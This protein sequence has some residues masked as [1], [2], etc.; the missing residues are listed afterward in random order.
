VELVA[1]SQDGCTDTAQKTLHF[2]EE[3]TIYWPSSFSPNNDGVND[4]FKIEGEFISLKDF[5]LLIYDRW[6]QQVFGSTNPTAV[7]DGKHPNGYSTHVAGIYAIQLRYRNHL[8]ELV[9]IFDEVTISKAGN[10]VGLR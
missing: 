5:E 6:G 2:I 7:W 8:G 3:T 10:K 4:V 1:T 9:V